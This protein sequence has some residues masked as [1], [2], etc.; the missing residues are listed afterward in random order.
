MEQLSR[1][2]FLKQTGT[3]A[4]AV[5]A[6]SAFSGF[7][8]LRKT[9]RPPAVHDRG[10]AAASGRAHDGPLVVHVPDP[11]AGEVRLMFGTREIVHHDPALVAR[12]LHATNER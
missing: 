5:G 9:R 2:T 6:I 10:I 12:L 11:R 3:G 8:F 7:P 4:A 1:R